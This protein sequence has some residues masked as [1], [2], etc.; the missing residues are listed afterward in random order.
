MF[1]LLSKVAVRLS[2]ESPAV[3]SSDV[4]DDDLDHRQ[5]VNRRHGIRTRD[6]GYEQLWNAGKDDIVRKILIYCW[7]KLAS[8]AKFL[9]LNEAFAPFK[10][11][12]QKRSLN[13]FSG[14]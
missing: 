8:F 14:G 10:Q 5:K 7:K 2:P 13:V 9:H 11:L 4:D 6:V 1:H 3:Q 12:F